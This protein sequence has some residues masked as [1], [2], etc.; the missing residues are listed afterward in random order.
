MTLDTAGASGVAPATAQPPGIPM[1]RL[2]EIDV[3]RTVAIAMMV[4]YHVV[5]DVELLSPGLGPDPFTGGWGALPEAT[6][7]LFLLVAGASLAVADAR[8]EARGH[9]AR[10]RFARHLR[11]AGIVLAAALVVSAATA[12]AFGDRYVRFGILHAIA[13]GTVVAAATV[14]LGAW[15]I[16]PGAAA[17]AA[18]VTVA[19]LGGSAWLLPVGLGPATVS[20]VDYWPLL[21]WLGP[22]LIGV[23]LGRLLYPGGA[24]CGAV[25]RA[26]AGLRVPGPLVVPGRHSL[27]VYLGHQ[28]L[29]IPLV[30]LIL[31][32]AGAEAS[33][34]P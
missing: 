10:Q 14:R 31:L 12:I 24:R 5:Y 11:R 27:I 2:W 3:A 17:V 29:L 22:M 13:A 34:P 1:A 28:L 26:V 15:N 18:G 8:A 23:G 16:L 30:W 6:G 21:P 9:S 19:G 32:A 7:S 25:S 33:G 20:S 4:T